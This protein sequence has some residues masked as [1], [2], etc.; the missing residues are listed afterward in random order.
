MTVIKRISPV[1][2]F[3]IL[4]ADA[5]AKL[6]DT[7]TTIEHSF[8]GN[9]IGSIHVPLKRPP[10]WDDLPDFVENVKKHVPSTATAVILMC[11]SG[12]RSM[13]AAKLLEVAGYQSLYNMEE[14]FEGDKDDNNHRNTLGGWRFHNL[15]WQQS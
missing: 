4:Q 2:A 6:I 13:H 15:P 10:N 8:V 12:A 3:D 7:R 9:P 14:G 1:E 5:Q 11:R